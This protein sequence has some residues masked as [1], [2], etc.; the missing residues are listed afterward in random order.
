MSKPKNA[1]LKWLDYATPAQKKALAKAAGTSRQ[2][3]AHI[4]AGRRKV[5]AQLAQRLAHA[6]QRF[7]LPPLDQRQLCKACGQC[8]LIK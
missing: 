8:P 4:A 1:M 2:Y 5:N 3:L 7:D 6:S